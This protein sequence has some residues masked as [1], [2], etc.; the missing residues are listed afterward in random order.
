M[1]VL[2]GANVLFLQPIVVVGGGHQGHGEAIPGILF[3]QNVYERVR[4]VRYRWYHV[5]LPCKATTKNK[6][7]IEKKENQKDRDVILCFYPIPFFYLKHGNRG[8]D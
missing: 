5:P 4:A 3:V 2:C 7:K 8:S 1:K 6:K